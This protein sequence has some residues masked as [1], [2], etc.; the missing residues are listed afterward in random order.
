MNPE[1]S[2]SVD[3]PVPD[4]SVALRQGTPLRVGILR[5][6]FYEELHPEV[7]NAMHEALS[8]IGKLGSVRDGL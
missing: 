3:E 7:D 2:T 6:Y 4:Y 5:R 1:E 8:V